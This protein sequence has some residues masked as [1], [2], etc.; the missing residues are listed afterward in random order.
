MPIDSISRSRS[1]AGTRGFNGTNAPPTLHTANHAAIAPGAFG[2][3][4]PMAASGEPGVAQLAGESS[5]V[6]RSSARVVA[7]PSR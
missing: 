2:A 7:T 3:S 4:T 5:A 1:A 6:A